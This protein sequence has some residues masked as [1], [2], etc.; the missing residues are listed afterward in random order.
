MHRLRQG[1]LDGNLSLAWADLAE[2]Y[3]D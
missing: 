3:R 1:I 2:H